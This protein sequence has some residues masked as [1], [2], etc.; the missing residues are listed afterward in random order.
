MHPVMEGTSPSGGWRR[1]KGM[2]DAHR[3]NKMVMTA[4]GAAFC[5][6]ALAW[7]SKRPRP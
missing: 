5:L 3:I 1:R 6:G 7:V 2:P 4:A